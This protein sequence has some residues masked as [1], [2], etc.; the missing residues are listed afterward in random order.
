M[1]HYGQRYAEGLLLLLKARPLEARG[2]PLTAVRAAAEQACTRSTA[3]EAHLFARRA[4]RFLSE[5]GGN[6]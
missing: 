3:C 1:R 4:E 6:T 5:R 2:A